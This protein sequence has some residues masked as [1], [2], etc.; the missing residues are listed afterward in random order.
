M[1]AKYWRLPATLIIAAAIADLLGEWLPWLRWA[2]GALAIITT[3]WIFL[4]SWYDGS[5]RL[6]EAKQRYAA[7]LRRIDRDHNPPPR[8]QP[9]PEDGQIAAEAEQLAEEWRQFQVTGEQ[10]YLK[11]LRSD[12]SIKMAAFP[13]DKRIHRY[14]REIA[15]ATL[16]GRSNSQKTMKS[17]ARIPRP[18][19]KAVMDGLVEL[20]L[21]VKENPEIPN[22]KYV[23]AQPHRENLRLLNEIAHGKFNLLTPAERWA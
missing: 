16:S 7:E 6:L 23:V 14:L 12:N 9:L 15:Q 8:R 18:K 10:V 11:I 1:S 13:A 20:G 4:Q 3:A 21:I 2:F 19:H 5:V 17:L 22:S